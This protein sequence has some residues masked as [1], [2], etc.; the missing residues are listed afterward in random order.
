MIVK[1]NP[2]KNYVPVIWRSSQ[3]LYAFTYT[4]HIGDTD[5]G[6]GGGGGGYT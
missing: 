5:R 3:V 2:V 6:G 1:C 4:E